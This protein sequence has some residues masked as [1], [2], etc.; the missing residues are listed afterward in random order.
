VEMK[1]IMNEKE[2]T[3]IKIRKER[4]ILMLESKKK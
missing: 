2:K 1:K 4:E 3:K